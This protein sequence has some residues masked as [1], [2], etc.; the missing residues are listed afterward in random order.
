MEFA[1]VC[2]EDL[3]FARTRYLLATTTADRCSSCWALCKAS[4]PITSSSS[5]SP[6]NKTSNTNPASKAQ[7]LRRHLKTARILPSPACFIIYRPNGDVTNATEMN[8][9]L[10]ALRCGFVF[11]S[12]FL[13]SHVFIQFHRRPGSLCSRENEDHSKMLNLIL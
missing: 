11:L 1:C 8:G 2:V 6:S 9:K 12:F 5:F 7:Y 3:S 10:S 13:S 4:R